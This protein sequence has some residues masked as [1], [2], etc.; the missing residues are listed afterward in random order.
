[1]QSGNNRATGRAGQFPYAYI[2]SKLAVLPE[3]GQLSRRESM[4]NNQDGKD[5]NGYIQ[6]PPRRSKSNN[7][8]V[9]LA[10]AQ[11]E[12]GG[13]SRFDEVPQSG[14]TYT[15]LR[16]RKMALRRKRSLSV[17]DLPVQRND[18]CASAG[19]QTGPMSNQKSTTTRKQKSDESGYDS[20]VTRKSSPRGSLKNGETSSNKTEDYDTNSSSRS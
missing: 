14:N 7:P 9:E 20:D 15:S 12:C 5:C 6:V 4:N 17:A 3:E 1:M 19:Q 11:S 2:R 8:D 16:A 13:N 18:R 10:S